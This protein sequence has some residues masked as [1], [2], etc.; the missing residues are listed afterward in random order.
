MVLVDVML[1]EVQ[2][3]LHSAVH[4]KVTI[5]NTAKRHNK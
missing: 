1:V 2:G 3:P 4:H 5:T